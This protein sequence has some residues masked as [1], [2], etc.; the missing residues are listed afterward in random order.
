MSKQRVVFKLLICM[1]VVNS[2]ISAHA[3]MLKTNQKNC[4]YTQSGEKGYIEYSTDMG[5]G[6]ALFIPNSDFYLTDSTHSGFVLFPYGYSVYTEANGCSLTLGGQFG[7]PNAH[8]KYLKKAG[9]TIT[10]YKSHYVLNK[11]YDNN[12]WIYDDYEKMTSVSWDMNGR[13]HYA[14][15]VHPSHIIWD[16]YIYYDF[17]YDKNLE[18]ATEFIDLLDNNMGFDYASG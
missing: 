18:N 9:A 16:F 14:S 2:S 11:I 6:A 7:G 8:I 1:C 15:F 10:G 17:S 3:Y 5:R 12:G 4:C 13:D